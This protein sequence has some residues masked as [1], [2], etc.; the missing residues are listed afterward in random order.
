[1]KGRRGSSQAKWRNYFFLP[2]AVFAVL[3][4]YMEYRADGSASVKPSQTQTPLG[5]TA[6]KKAKKAKEDEVVVPIPAGLSSLE[7]VKAHNEDA[8]FRLGRKHRTDKVS[9]HAYHKTYAQF[10][11]REKTQKILEIGISAGN[12]IRMWLEYFP[13]AEVHGMELHM[14]KDRWRIKTQRFVPWIGSMTNRTYLRW[15]K[16]RHIDRPFDIIIDDGE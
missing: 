12:S 16:Q 4:L 8:L 11:D 10:F 9:H 1:M 3:L 5:G 15:F 7:E 13:N 6:A 14:R 2:L